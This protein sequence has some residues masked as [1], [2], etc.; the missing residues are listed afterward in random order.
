[1]NQSMGNQSL[2]IRNNLVDYEC[3]SSQM[4]HSHS[5]ISGNEVSS[6]RNKSCFS[7]NDPGDLSH[8]SNFEDQPRGSF[9]PNKNME[10][11]NSIDQK[12]PNFCQGRKMSFFGQQMNNRKQ[13]KKKS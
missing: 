8:R 13:S 2:A 5:D 11:S 6:N 10:R 9:S 4:S 3:F 1:M 12:S 7:N